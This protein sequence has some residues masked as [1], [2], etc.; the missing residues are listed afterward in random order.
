[1]RL[2]VKILKDGI[3]MPECRDSQVYSMEVYPPGDPLGFVLEPGKIT[4]IPLGFAVDVPRGFELQIRG[5]PG[6]IEQKIWTF[7]TYFASSGYKSRAT[8]ENE[9]SI[10]MLNLNKESKRFLAGDRIANMVLIQTAK[11]TW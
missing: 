4:E 1:M 2:K 9:L 10:W 6:L 5:L 11:F 8:T 3:R 7:N